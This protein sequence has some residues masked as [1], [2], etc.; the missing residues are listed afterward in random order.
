MGK[1]A[2]VCNIL[3][4]GFLSDATQRNLLRGWVDCHGYGGVLGQGLR[5]RR[6]R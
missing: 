5:C 3:V 1:G 6:Y 2:E 4:R